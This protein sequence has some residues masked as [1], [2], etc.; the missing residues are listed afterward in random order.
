M[1]QGQGWDGA[2]ESWALMVGCKQAV[3]A[4]MVGCKQA[5]TAVMV[6]CRPKLISS[7]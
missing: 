7:D 6:G 5:V 2:G 1:G 4:V 3:T